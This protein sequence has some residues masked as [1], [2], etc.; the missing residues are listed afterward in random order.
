M[1][2]F[3]IGFTL[4]FTIWSI[5]YIWLSGFNFDARGDEAAGAFLFISGSCFFGLVCGILL[6]SVNLAQENKK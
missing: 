3:K 1:H 2:K 4:I 6:D 5:L